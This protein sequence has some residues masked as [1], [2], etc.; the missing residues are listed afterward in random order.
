MSTTLKNN[1]YMHLE[2]VR[3]LHQQQEFSFRT[4]GPPRSVNPT[5]G[6]QDH[7]AKELLEVAKDPTDIYEW[8]DCVILSFDG[9]LRAGYTP[10]QIAEALELKQL[11]NEKRRWPDWQTAEPGK[12][13]EH[14]RGDD[15]GN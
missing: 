9:A 11:K 2:L 6:V 7:L 4:F 15:H 10:E 13:I 12:A 8:I 1:R 14:I 3:H 5:A